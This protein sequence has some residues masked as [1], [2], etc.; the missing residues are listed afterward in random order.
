M[1]LKNVMLLGFV[2]RAVEYLDKHMDE[3]PDK[4]LAEL[5]NIDLE[6]LKAELCDNLDSSLG[7][8][9]STMSTLL[10]AGNEAFDE[11]LEDNVGKTTVSQK[12]DRMFD[13]DFESKD[14]QDKQNELAKLLSFY[15]LEEDD[16]IYDKSIANDSINAKDEEY[17]DEIK[18][19][20]ASEEIPEVKAEPQ[21]NES[22]NKEIDSIFSEI[23]NNE[24]DNKDTNIV[25]GG[26]VSYS[27]NEPKEEKTDESND[28]QKIN[29][30]IESGEKTYV[31]SMISD[32]REQFI[33]DE[34]EKQEQFNKNKEIYENIAKKYPYL[35]N[36][37]I[38][39][40]YDLKE[41]L[42]YEYNFDEKVIVL[43]R[44]S[45]NDVNNLRKFAEICLSHEYSIN[46]DE[47]KMIVDIFKEFINTKDRIIS[48]I[49]EIANQGSLLNGTYE[50]YNVI[51]NEE[52]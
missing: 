50:G 45:F 35:S 20:V 21:N 7:T 36:G 4:R 12:L 33:K 49:Y 46:A 44:I 6:S 27:A 51:T 23:V 48:N 16:E 30:I 28:T 32:L 40:V 5:K 2:N 26:K 41:K 38:K 8:M 14:S 34:T 17:F 18:R 15:N 43:H 9:Q 10:K 39:S 13:V 52:E 31:S 47:D 1:K 24:T 37:F 11:F 42:N 22:E 25:F 19:N 29:P 3:G